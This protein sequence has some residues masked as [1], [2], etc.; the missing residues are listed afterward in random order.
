[1][2]AIIVALTA[3]Y[4]TP[5]PALPHGFDPA[6]PNVKWFES[7]QYPPNY[8]NS[9]CGKGD[10]FFVSDYWPGKDDAG[11]DGFW[12]RLTADDAAPIKYPDGTIREAVAPGEY[13]I[14]NEH[15]NRE[16]DDLDNP[17]DRSV[18]WATVN[19]MKFSRVWCFIRHPQGN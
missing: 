10:A 3:L 15:V 1:M 18:M 16:G 5:A 4:T 11:N 19:D 9:C 12:V 17:F 6:S 7:K 2:L 13:F 8:T 14:P